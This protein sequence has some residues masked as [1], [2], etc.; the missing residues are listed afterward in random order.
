MGRSFKYHRP[1]GI[2][3][4]GAEEP[5]ALI[6]LE[7]GAGTQPNLRATQIELY[8]GLAAFSQN[9]WPSLRFDVG[10]INDLLSR[11]LP[12]GFYYKTFMWPR[13]AWIAYEYFIRRAAGL[14]RA[15]GGPDPD[16]YDKMHV[17]CDVHFVVVIGGRHTT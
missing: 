5:N 13:R 8:A 9:R 16:Y 10:E 11:V 15:P 12:S 17:H 14:G 2:L 7:T 3:S 6:Q 4:C 1:R